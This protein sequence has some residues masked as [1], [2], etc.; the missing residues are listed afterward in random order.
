MEYS[1]VVCRSW[2]DLRQAVVDILDAPPE[3]FRKIAIDTLNGMERLC[4]EHICRKN[5]VDSI[6]DVGGGFGKGYTATAEAMFGL[7]QDLDA[8]R[9]KHKLHII[10]LGH[11]HVKTFNDPNGPA[12]DRY[13]LRMNAKV[14]AIWMEWSDMVLFAAFEATVKGGTRGK[15]IEDPMKK[16]KA[17]G[18]RR[19]IYTTQ[20]PA[21]MAKNRYNLPV[22]IDM[23]WDAFAKAIG[24]DRREA[25]L[26][27]PP[28]TEADVVVAVEARLTLGK[29]APTPEEAE[30]ISTKVLTGKTIPE[31]IA[32]VK[33][34][35]A[36]KFMAAAIA[37]LR[38]GTK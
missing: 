3:G 28:L 36:D 38:G 14:A 32:G 24:W 7:K 35:R 6:E 33:A 2:A 34:G 20:D 29:F 22:D 37:E 1:Q 8:L 15:E 11:S 4:I 19:V 5:N 13:E 9:S 23:S 18:L 21:Y 10:L 26:L 27:P 31:A 25:A 30:A 17:T 12:Y 16:G